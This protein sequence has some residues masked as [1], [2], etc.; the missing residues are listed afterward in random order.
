MVK[1]YKKPK[2]GKLVP[3]VRKHHAR[4]IM[5]HEPDA[6][7]AFAEGCLRNRYFHEQ[8]LARGP[9]CLG[10][11]RRFN[12]KVAKVRSRIEKHHE[13]YIRL[14]IGSELPSSSNDILREVVEREFDR[15]PDCRRC[16]AE[17][18]EYFQ[19][20]LKLVFP[21]HAACQ[22]RCMKRRGIL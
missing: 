10:C 22:E 18:S 5:I 3:K 11:N 21:M 1:R 7:L 8:V 9:K 20:C 12:R 2:R 17:N 19:G 4:E 16:H 15:V 13:S 6:W 14:C